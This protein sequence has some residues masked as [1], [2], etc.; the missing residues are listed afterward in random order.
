MP[1]QQRE[2]QADTE[3]RIV[4]RNG[5]SFVQPG[6]IHH[7]AGSGQNALAMSADDSMVDRSGA[8]EIVGIDDEAG[9][10]DSLSS[11]SLMER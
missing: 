6:L 4:P 7:Q 11:G 1:A 10:G 8:A 3:A 9:H 2:M 5:D